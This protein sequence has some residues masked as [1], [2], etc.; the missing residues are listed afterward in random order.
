MAQRYGGKFSPDPAA[1]E[2][3]AEAP[4]LVEASFKGRAPARYGL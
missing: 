2:V 4:P 1:N 3:E